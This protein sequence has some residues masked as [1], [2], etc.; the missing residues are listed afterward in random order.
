MS[1]PLLPFAAPTEGQILSQLERLEAGRD[2]FLQL[3]RE[4][5]ELLKFQDARTLENF[6]F[7]Q[8]ANSWS[9]MHRSVVEAIR[10]AQSLLTAR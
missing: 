7:I 3:L 1:K 5:P 8:P 4:N 2:M 9:E 6:G 10:F